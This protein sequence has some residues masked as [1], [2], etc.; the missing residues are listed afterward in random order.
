MLPGGHL[1]V[2]LRDVAQAEVLVAEAAAASPRLL[3]SAEVRELGR[4]VVLHLRRSDGVAGDA[5][6]S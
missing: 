1:L 2:Q 4:G 6:V 5:V 3:T